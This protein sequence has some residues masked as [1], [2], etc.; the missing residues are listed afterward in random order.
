M[1]LIQ[2]ILVLIAVGVLLW[3]V[4]TYGAAYM[5]GKILQI[6][7]VAVVVGVILWLLAVFGL[8]A[9]LETIRVGPR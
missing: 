2:M 5:D 9:G 7:N 3:A 6:L 4:N 8:F 1:P